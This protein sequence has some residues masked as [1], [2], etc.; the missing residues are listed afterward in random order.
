MR[1][2]LVGRNGSGKTTLMKLLAD[3]LKPDEGTIKLG[4][5]VKVVSFEQDRKQLNP[6]ESIK[7][8]LAPAG[9]DMV[10]YRD[11]PVHIITWAKRFLFKPEQINSPVSLIKEHLLAA[12]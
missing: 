10:I 4:F 9:G 1:I 12:T 6:Q 8:A 7:E 3:K 2:G 5:N 11:K